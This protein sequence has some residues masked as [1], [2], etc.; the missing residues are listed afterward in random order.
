MVNVTDNVTEDETLS[1]LKSVLKSVTQ[2]QDDMLIDALFSEEDPRNRQDWLK[3]F[4]PSIFSTLSNY[5]RLEILGDALLKT[6]FRDFLFRHNATYTESD[7]T[8]LSNYYMATEG[9]SEVAVKLKLTKFVRFP[10]FDDIGEADDEAQ[11]V[12][13]EK[14][15]KNIAAD[16]YEA[17]IGAI[18]VTS[19]RISHGLSEILCIN[20]MNKIYGG[21]NPIMKIDDEKRLSNVKTRVVQWLEGLGVTPVSSSGESVKTNAKKKEMFSVDVRDKGYTLYLL[22]QQTAV[23][24][25][26]SGTDFAKN[27]GDN[28]YVTVNNTIPGYRNLVYEELE[29]AL[30]RNGINQAYVDNYRRRP[31]LA[32]LDGYYVEVVTPKKLSVPSG[33]GVPGFDVY[34]LVGNRVK[35]DGNDEGPREIL[36]TACYPSGRYMRD[37]VTMS[38]QQITLDLVTKYKAKSSSASFFTPPPSGSS[39][40]SV[41]IGGSVGATPTPLSS[42]SSSSSSSSDTSI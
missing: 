8:N 38:R 10:N 24:K 13:V 37:G 21:K 35:G 31:G 11:R 34:Q 17:F 30:M 3:V 40:P 20:I 18:A 15:R 41:N 16:I 32:F 29:K 26:L 12:R 23:L 25:A 39:V 6:Y 4:T 7:I 27:Y 2:E 1:F 28:F 42:M 33:P 36:Y 9:Q 19:R 14:L 22:P 5:E